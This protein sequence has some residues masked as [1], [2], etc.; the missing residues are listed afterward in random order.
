MAA[1]SPVSSTTTLVTF[2]VQVSGSAIPGYYG[3]KSIE[4]VREVNKVPSARITLIDGSSAEQNFEISDSDDFKPGAEVTILAGYQSTNNSIF[5]GIVIRHGVRINASGD[6]E[7][8]IECR[9]KA[10]KMTVA[11]N[12]AYYGDGS[13][14]IKDSDLIS[15]LIGNSGC[16]ASVDATTV[17]HKEIVQYYVSDWDLMLTRAEINSLIVTVEDGTVNVK[18]PGVS[19]SAV[20]SLTYGTDLLEFSADMDARWQLSSVQGTTWDMSSQAIVQSSG[21]DPSVNSQGNITSSTLADVL[22]VSTFNLQS[23]G[24]EDS[25]SLTAWADAQM[26]R[27]WLS[28][29]RGRAK[30][31]GSDLAKPGV[32]ID[33]AGVGDRFNGSLFVTGTIQSIREGNWTTEIKFGLDPNWFYERPDIPAPTASGILPGFNGLQIGKVKQLDQDPD[34]EYRI[35]VT[36]PVMQDDSKGVWARMSTYYATNA[37][38]N[39]FYPEIG[40][41][42]IL[43]YLNG[44][45]R[46]PIILGSVYSSSNT[47]PYDPTADN[48]T[49]AIVTNSKMK[50]EFDDENKVIT[51]ETPGGNNMVFTDEDKKI[52][53]TDQNGNSMEMSEDG[54]TVKSC[55]DMTLDAS[56]DITIKATGDITIQSTGDTNVK[57]TGNLA[58]QATSDATLKGMNVTAQADAA[59]T[60]KGS[61]TAEV[62]ASGNTTIKGAMVM[63]N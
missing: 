17:E 49:K 7:L 38:G 14:T 16:T 10:I 1:P 12:N 13:T 25:D 59:F 35:L 34:N 33:V 41:E 8:V 6:S 28:K 30:F 39:F 18:K 42:V 50:I 2:E 5:S 4:V 44:D 45:P 3:V 9:D 57:A 53:I 62:S 20:L 22:G 15:T 24:Q 54:I 61:A 58:M 31:Q 21:S 56:G 51:I 40:D 37:A 11:R 48:Y 29:I 26:Q 43:G 47:A 63:I 23:T 46:S 60:G 55:K 52:T 27:S 36:I 19:E 32:I